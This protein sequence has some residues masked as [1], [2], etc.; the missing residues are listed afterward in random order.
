MPPSPNT[1]L[2]L[3]GLRFIA[4]LYVFIFHIHIRW[5]LTSQP[6]LKNIFDQGAVGMSI[7]FMLSGFVLA[8]SYADAKVS[9]RTYLVN[10]F[11]RIYPVYLAAALVT[12]PWIGIPISDGTGASVL[13]TSAQ[14]LL[15]VFANTFAVQAWFPSLFPMWNVGASWSIS[16]EMFCYLTLPLALPALVKL[17]KKRLL[18]TGVTCWLIGSLPGL[19]G[20]SFPGPL[21]TIYYSMPIFRLPEF[22]LG[23]I[24]FLYMRSEKSSTKIGLLVVPVSILLF[25]YLAFWGDKMPLYVGHSWIALP[26]IA[27][28]IASLSLS[29]GI[30]SAVLS[31]RVFVWLGKTSYCFYSFQALLIFSLIDHHSTIVRAIPMLSNNLILLSVSFCALVCASAIGY[32]GLEEP[33]RKWIKR[34]L[35]EDSK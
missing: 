23:A 20:A 4:A 18:L 5:P 32:Y 27:L 10:R 17:P 7:F 1:I 34:R 21:G 14:S 6:A 8:F 15:L 30:P 19:I 28:A 25:T 3:T 26:C 29:K 12:L 9:T 16:V 33:S 24:V 35:S 2:P 13:K 22:V 31:N 11:A